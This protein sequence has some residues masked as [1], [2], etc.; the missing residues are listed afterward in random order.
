MA[1][2]HPPAILI[3][4]APGLDFLNSIAQPTNT[5]I[6]WI[7]SGEGLLNWL[8]EVGLVPAEAPEAFRKQALPGELDK[9][10]DQARELREWFRGVVKQH[11]GRP[12]GLEAFAELAPLNR[13][14]QRD[15]SYVQI[16][17]RDHEGHGHFGVQR[18]RRWRS[19]ESLLLP[20][21]EALANLV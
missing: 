4:G 20:V 6:D 5:V 14:L 3:A 15:E 21:G 18:M 19:P 7:D 2:W 12:L 10:A 9:V 1:A 17:P 13:L 16:A 8:G 11:K